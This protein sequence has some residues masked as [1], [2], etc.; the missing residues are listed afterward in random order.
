M[1][2]SDRV[3]LL[4]YGH[5]KRIWL[6]PFL[7]V[8]NPDLPR[9]SE[10]LSLPSQ[11]LLMVQFGLFVDGIKDCIFHHRAV[12][13]LPCNALPVQGRRVLSFKLY[14]RKLKYRVFIS[15]VSP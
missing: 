3:L 13:L 6:F 2:C 5:G 4:A 15:P 12:E 8:T 10:G 7:R 14:G 11:Q 9:E 1:L